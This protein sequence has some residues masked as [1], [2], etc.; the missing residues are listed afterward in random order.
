MRLLREE[1]RIVP[2]AQLEFTDYVII[3][4]L[5]NIPPTQLMPIYEQICAQNTDPKSPKD[6]E[7][8]ICQEINVHVTPTFKPGTSLFTTKMDQLTYLEGNY[9][10]E[11]PYNNMNI[12]G[13]FKD[14]LVSSEAKEAF[15]IKKN[16]PID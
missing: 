4:N 1:S 11:L 2:G 15:A 6:G 5:T 8:I 3:G 10:A 16:L 12:I 9:T 7:T 13:S 14:L